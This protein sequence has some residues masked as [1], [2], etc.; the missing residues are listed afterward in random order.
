MKASFL[1]TKCSMGGLQKCN[2]SH[3]DVRGSEFEKVDMSGSLLE[4]TDFSGA[5]LI[6]TMWRDAVAKKARFVKAD[7]FLSHA[8][9]K[10]SFTECNFVGV[11]AKRSTWLECQSS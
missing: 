6:H 4:E 2:L 1:R 11:S 3:A 5:K 7:L 8:T 9:G 10:A